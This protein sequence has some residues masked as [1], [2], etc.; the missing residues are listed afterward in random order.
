[1][2]NPRS[3]AVVCFLVSVAAGAAEAPGPWKGFTS[4]EL[5]FGGMHP[6]VDRTP[7]LTGTPYQSS[8]GNGTM[9]TVQLEG[10]HFFWTGFGSFGLGFSAAYAEKYA[11]A[12]YAAGG[13][14]PVKT[15]LRILPLKLLAVYRMDYA[16][17][18]WHVPFVPF[19][20][21]GI[22]YEPWWAST[23]G[24]VDYVGTERGGGG[25]LGY[26]LTAGL[27]FLLD[28]IEPRLAKDAEVDAGI[29]HTYFL[30][31]YDSD[32]VPAFGGQGIDL[33]NR[34][35]MFGLAFDF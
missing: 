19:L 34:R 12:K 26:G 15:S 2:I 23:G 18:R 31:E 11:G 24:S 30:A 7:G 6:D 1:M 9:L 4:V 16:A 33:S 20:K 21:A 10:D 35:V 25:R 5:K 14:A 22:I 17:I 8:F 13:P 27:A 32:V 28:V 3:V 29:L